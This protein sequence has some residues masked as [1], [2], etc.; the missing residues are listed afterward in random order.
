M[1]GGNIYISVPVGK[2][3]I[4]FNAHR[5]FMLQQLLM[6]SHSVSW[7]SIHIRKMVILSTM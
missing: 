3:H 7:L 5:I 1:A 6:L 4:E 2:E